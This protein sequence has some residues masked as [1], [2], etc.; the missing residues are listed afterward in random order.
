MFPVLGG[1]GVAPVSVL[2]CSELPKVLLGSSWQ[3]WHRNGSLGMQSGRMNHFS[4][5]F[6]PKLEPGGAFLA[7]HSC[8]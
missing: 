4:V 6:G 2:E 7:L 5:P 3:L 8:R 1:L